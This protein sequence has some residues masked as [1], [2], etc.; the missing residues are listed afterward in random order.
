[1]K[2]SKK[3]LVNPCN[4]DAG[5]HVWS[6]AP[7]ELTAIRCLALTNAPAIT[8]LRSECEEVEPKVAGTCIFPV[9]G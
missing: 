9:D 3:V 2:T 8:S 1:M 6:A 5:F 4:K 7:A